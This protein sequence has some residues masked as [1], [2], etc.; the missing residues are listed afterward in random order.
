METNVTVPLTDAGASPPS[1]RWAAGETVGNKF[2]LEDRL[3]SGGM[4]EVYRAVELATG[5]AVAIKMDAGDRRAEVTRFK[6]ELR[7][8]R[9]LG[10]PCCVRVGEIGTHA[11]RWFFTME[12]VE[13]G[14]L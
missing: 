9:R 10:H 11:K 14:S 7:A 1:S 8:A 4:G 3:G 5:E 6:R 12:Y 2:R 13:G